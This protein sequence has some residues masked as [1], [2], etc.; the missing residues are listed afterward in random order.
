MN[1]YPVQVWTGPK[2][3]RNGPRARGTVAVHCEK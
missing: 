2:E 1:K 3:Q